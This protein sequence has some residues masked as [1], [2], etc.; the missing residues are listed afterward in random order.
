MHERASLR[1]YRLSGWPSGFQSLI[2]RFNE[3]R[4]VLPPEP[5]KQSACHSVKLRR[6]KKW[7]GTCI[8]P[9]KAFFPN[10][11]PKQPK[12]VDTQHA[13]RN[14]E[15]YHENPLQGQIAR[16][17]QRLSPEA[18]AR[19]KK[20]WEKRKDKANAQRREK[21]ATDKEF[22]EAHKADSRKRWETR[23]H[24]VNPMRR[25]GGSRYRP[26]KEKS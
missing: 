11:L 8:L 5:D 23:K 7:A 6:S 12:L 4:A 14:R 26:K 19:S 1:D 16:A 25:K 15:R 21:Y 18:K 3:N 20:Y 9:T 17:R 24:I 2:T 10:G 13:R 22:R